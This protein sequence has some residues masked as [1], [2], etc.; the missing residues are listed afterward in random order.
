[1]SVA[2]L[3]LVNVIGLESEF[4]EVVKDILMPFEFEFIKPNANALN[5][6]HLTPFALDNPYSEALEQITQVLISADI[7]PQMTAGQLKN[8]SS[9]DTAADITQ[10]S[11]RLMELNSRIGDLKH[12]ISENEQALSQL[13]PIKEAQLPFDMLFAMKY[14]DMRFGRMPESSYKI[15]DT[16]ESDTPVLFIPAYTE[17]EYVWGVCFTPQSTKSVADALLSSLYFERTWLSGKLAGT[18]KEAYKNIFEQNEALREELQTLQSARESM[19][20]KQRK[21]LLAAYSHYK[22]LSDCYD[23]RRWALKSDNNFYV[24]GWIDQSDLK[25]FKAAAKKHDSVLTIVEDPKEVKSLKPPTKLKNMFGI[26]FF[27]QFTKMYGL[28]DYNEIDP[29]FIVA[30]TYTLFFGIMFGDVGQGLVLCLAGVLAYYKLH[31]PLGKI[32]AVIGLSSFAFGF[33][34]GSVFGLENLLPGLKVLEG[35]NTLFILL[36]AA[37]GGLVLIGLAMVLNIINGIR[38]RRPDKYLFSQNG[39]CGFV[40]FFANITALILTFTTDIRLYSPVYIIVTTLIPVILIFLKE[41]LTKLM[42]G[43]KKPWPEKW[44]EY[45][46]ENF[47]ELFEV[48]LSFLSNTI[49]YVRIGAFAISH[50]GMMLVVTSM[51]EMLGAPGNIIVMVFGNIF[52]ICLEGLIVGIQCLR[53]QFYEFFSRFYDGTGKPFTPLSTARK[54]PRTVMDKNADNLNI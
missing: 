38:Q 11:K 9:K 3:K 19:T 26:R 24:F 6:K 48:L 20:L 5:A 7:K 12:K 49:S 39:I 14:I 8:H 4:D 29:T 50:A 33:M 52:V 21:F 1:M 2:K 30:I 53:L 18:P 47:F 25:R 42:L 51:A 40:L 10:F 44:G 46:T 28:P 34:Y 43:V 32:I 31:M 13:A 16:I 22:Y 35:N 17:H 23:V 27:E 41:P 54:A 15:L 37:G 45:A 36:F